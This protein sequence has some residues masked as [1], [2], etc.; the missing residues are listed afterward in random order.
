MTHQLKTSQ[1]PKPLTI[2]EDGNEGERSWCP[3]ATTKCR[4]DERVSQDFCD[5]GEGLLCVKNWARA[6]EMFARGVVANPSN[7]ACW[8]GLSRVSQNTLKLG[9]YYTDPKISRK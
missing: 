6:R 4:E 9:K 5:E 7:L 2:V 1:A 3:L 8:N